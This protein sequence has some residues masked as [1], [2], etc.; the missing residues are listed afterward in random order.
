M[1]A[2]PQVTRASTPAAEVE[3][4]VDF[5]SSGSIGTGTAAAAL[6][7]GGAFMAAVPALTATAPAPAAATAA[8]AATAGVAGFTAGVGAAGR[9]APGRLGFTVIRAVSLGGAVLI[10][11]VPDFD[12]GTAA[13][14]AFGLSGETALGATAPG[15][16]GLTGLTAVGVTPGLTGWTGCTGLTAVGVVPATTGL[17]ATGVPVGAG[18]EGVMALTTAAPAAAPATAA[19]ATGRTGFGAATGTA[20]GGGG[21]GLAV[22]ETTV[23]LLA[24]GRRGGATVGLT[25][26][27]GEG[28][29]AAGG[30]MDEGALGTRGGGATEVVF[31]WG[32]S[33]S[34]TD[35]DDDGTPG[36]DGWLD[37]MVAGR[38]GMAG[39]ASSRRVP[40]AGGA[41]MEAVFFAAV[42]GT[43]GLASV[44]AAGLGT[45]G[46]TVGEESIFSATGARAVGGVTVC[47]STLVSRTLGTAG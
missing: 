1:A 12:C 23:V 7:A 2:V 8:P 21:I 26:V 40:G 10:A 13:T 24:G 16:T 6:G 14:G 38:I 19:A 36:V 29:G 37:R 18:A 43:K 47:W 35:V 20:V 22:E 3:R 31:F 11:V 30:F 17:T 4:T 27:E 28:S 46:E 44:T 42:G 39:A 45:A 25:E 32:A 41:G 34:S 15:T 33:G 5:S 9:A